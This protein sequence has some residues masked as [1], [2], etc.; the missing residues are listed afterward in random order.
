M[1][2]SQF[3]VA[4]P[5]INHSSER[6]TEGM[7]DGDAE[8]STKADGD[9]DQAASDDSGKDAKGA[10]ENGNGHADTKKE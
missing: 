5:D 8:E 7:E 9:A 2:D 1:A 3:R 10:E 6:K 4:P